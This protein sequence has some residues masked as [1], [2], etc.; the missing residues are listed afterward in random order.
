MTCLTHR[1]LVDQDSHIERQVEEMAEMMEV[2]EAAGEEDHQ[3]QQDPEE[4]RTIETMAQSQ[5]A[6]NQSPLMEIALKQKPFTRMD[7]L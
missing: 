3:G 1:G 6:K 4:I 5:V 7:R 2:V